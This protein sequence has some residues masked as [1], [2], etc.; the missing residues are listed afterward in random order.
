MI[1]QYKEL[2]D[3]GVI[4]QEE[5]E[6]KKEELL[7]QFNE[8][9]SEEV[10]DTQQGDVLHDR[11]SEDIADGS[12]KI[13]SEVNVTSS[14]VSHDSLK[15][16]ATKFFSTLSKPAKIGIV[17][18]AIILC[19]AIIAG[20]FGSGSITGSWKCSY[21]MLAGQRYDA[22]N[23]AQASDYTLE[24]KSNS[25]KANI[26]GV[27]ATG[28]WEYINSVDMGESGEVDLYTFTTESG[29]QLTVEHYKKYDNIA[30]NM[31]GG[32]DSNNYIAFIRK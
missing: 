20:G 9:S 2:L 4:T 22:S 19:I 18:V 16:N 31:Y 28:T 27:E 6:A 3:M 8:Q 23:D 7:S 26:Y 30:F 32:M 17:A 1:K 29:A 15:D 12:T 10:I 21:V 25:F 14:P 13:E 11:V 5:F 24:I